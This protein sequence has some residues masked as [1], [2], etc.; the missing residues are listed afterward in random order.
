MSIPQRE[1]DYLM[2]V[3]KVFSETDDI[4][5]GPAPIRWQRNINAIQSREAFILDFYRGSFELR[6]YTTNKRYR[7]TIIFLRYDSMGRHTNPDGTTF[8]GPHVHLY[9]EGFN[10]R[11][12]FPV[13]EIGVDSSL[14][15]E[16]VFQKILSYSNVIQVPQIHLSIF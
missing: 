15:M 2:S 8:D 10:D 16:E 9:R 3:E 13:T 1:Y 5:L 6:K 14:A 7:Q 11:F 12:A 4:E